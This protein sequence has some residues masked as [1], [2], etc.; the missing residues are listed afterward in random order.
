LHALYTFLSDEPPPL[1]GVCVSWQE[2][3][4]SRS[5]STHTR[6][7]TGFLATREKQLLIWI[8]RRLPAWV[9][10]DHLTMLALVAMAGAG[11]S[12]WAARAWPPAL[13]LVVVSLA[14]NWFGDSLDGTLARVRG[15]ER[16]RYGFYVDHVL[17]IAGASLLFGGMSL[18]GFMTPVVGLAVLVAYL[19]VSAEVFLATAVQGTFRMSFL[20]VG[21][22]ELRIILS[23]GTLALFTHPIVRPF[24]FGPFLLFDVGGVV[25]VLGMLSAFL[26]SAIRTTATLHRAEPLPKASGEPKRMACVMRH[27]MS[28]VVGPRVS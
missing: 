20:S 15:H 12:F 22:T 25:A 24:G 9:N 10:S 7:N 13:G 14:I 18:S 21:P 28:T 17:D 23:I 6:I 19:L 27:T 16:P 26:M 4:V 8:A 5:I 11:A 3:D 2:D 1:N